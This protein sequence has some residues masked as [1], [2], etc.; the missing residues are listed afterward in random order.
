L[1]RIVMFR[2][3]YTRFGGF[4]QALSLSF[5][6]FMQSH[7]SPELLPPDEKGNILQQT[8]D[9]VGPYALHDFFLYYGP[10]TPCTA[11]PTASASR[12]AETGQWSRFS[13]RQAYSSA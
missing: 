10:S 2:C 4:T 9:V 12:R 6:A 3:Y 8:E 13:R 1:W 5:Y 7:S 11:H